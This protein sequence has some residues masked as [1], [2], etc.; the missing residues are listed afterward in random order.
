MSLHLYVCILLKLN[1]LKV[2]LSPFPKW[3]ATHLDFYII[4]FHHLDSTIK[5]KSFAVLN[6]NDNKIGLFFTARE[7]SN[8]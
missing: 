1:I 4:S 5:Y 6:K 2:F 8:F 3:K 7:V